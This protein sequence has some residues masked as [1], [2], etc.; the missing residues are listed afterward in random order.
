MEHSHMERKEFELKAKDKVVQK[1]TRDGLVDENLADGTTKKARPGDLAQE[2]ETGKA[3]K[4]T[5]EP[6]PRGQPKRRAAPR[7]RQT[8]LRTEPQ[9]QGKK[10]A[11]P[12]KLDEKQ[13]KA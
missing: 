12:G 6:K 3:T 13:K 10:A 5:P 2:Q 9:P 1:M 8:Q 11:R 7:K 4:P